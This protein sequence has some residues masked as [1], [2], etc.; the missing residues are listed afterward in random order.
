MQAKVQ[1]PES[2]QLS[3]IAEDKNIKTTDSEALRRELCKKGKE[4]AKYTNVPDIAGSNAS[5]C[6]LVQREASRKL[7]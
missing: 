5:L 1:R 3:A 2:S 4:A 7:R 6:R